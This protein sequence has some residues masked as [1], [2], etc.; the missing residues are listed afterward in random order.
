MEDGEKYRDIVTCIK[1]SHSLG[2]ECH[3]Y[4]FLLHHEAIL[5]KFGCLFPHQIN[6][7]FTDTPGLVGEQRMRMR[8]D[9]V[10]RKM[11]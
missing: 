2:D 6:P 7:A 10:R 9:D 3:K 11:R 4:N 5:Y 1:H 8:H